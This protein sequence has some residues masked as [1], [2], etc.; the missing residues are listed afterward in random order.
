LAAQGVPISKNVPNDGWNIREA[1]RSAQAREDLR[2]VLIITA[3]LAD[4][5]RLRDIEDSLFGVV[6]ETWPDNQYGWMRLMYR[7]DRLNDSGAHAAASELFQSLPVEQL[8]GFY[9][10]YLQGEILYCQ[11][12]HAVAPAHPFAVDSPEIQQYL[13]LRLPSSLRLR[14]AQAAYVEFD[15]LRARQLLNLARRALPALGSAGG[16]ACE[17]EAINALDRRL[18]GIGADEGG[19]VGT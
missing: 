6:G 5:V 11:L 10:G 15:V 1:N 16:E 18:G 8:S 14:A 12:V 19:Q 3:M 4:G 7:G 13:R 9:A 17:R 2:C